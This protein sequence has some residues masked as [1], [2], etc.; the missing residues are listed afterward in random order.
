MLEEPAKP[1]GSDPIADGQASPEGESLTPGDPNQ[2]DEDPARGP[3]QTGRAPAGNPQHP[4]EESY[5]Q[6]DAGGA[7]HHYACNADGGYP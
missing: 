5:S 6:L 1:G 7:D 4:D 2:L 3:R